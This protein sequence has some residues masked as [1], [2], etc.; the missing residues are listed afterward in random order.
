MIFKTRNETSPSINIELSGVAFNYLSL[1]SMQL[2][3]GENQHDMLVMHVAGLPPASVTSFDGVP[4]TCTWKQ[5]KIGHEFRGYVT[6]I[7]P[8]F[9]SANGTVND[10]PFQEA[11]IYCMGMSSLMRGKKSRLWESPSLA[12]IVKDMAK[13]YRFSYSI[14]NDAFSFSRLTQNG[15]SD[16]EFLIRVAD[17]L[18]LVVTLHGTHLHVFDRY[19]YL[20]R[21]ISYNKLTVPLAKGTMKTRPGQILTLDGVFGTVTPYSNVN[22]ERITSLDNRGVLTTTNTPDRKSGQGKPLT[23][24]LED[25][26]VTNFIAPDLAEK[27]INSRARKKFPYEAQVSLTGTSGIKPGGVVDVDRF[28]GKFDG[29]WYVSSVCHKITLD[30]YFTDVKILKDSTNEETY[31]VSPVTKFRDP[32]GSSLQNNTWRAATQWEETYG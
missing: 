1:L 14:P 21:Q 22:Q 28:G 11:H 19:K 10:S 26:V 3:L 13:E 18:G 2:E 7:E 25:Q 20:G 16:W 5:G 17:Y 32:P 31:R 27:I 12:S 8:H 6:F 29:L 9:R 24:R 4:V 30:K 23:S 15:E